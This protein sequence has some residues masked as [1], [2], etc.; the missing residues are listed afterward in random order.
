[1]M[2]LTFMLLGAVA[3][4]SSR[5]VGAWMLALGFGITHIGFGL[6]IARRHGG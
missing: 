6:W 1:M 3:L 4:F 2:G 5:A